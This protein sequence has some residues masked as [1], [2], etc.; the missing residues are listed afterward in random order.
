M[1]GGALTWTNATWP[2]AFF[3]P[4]GVRYVSVAGRAVRGNRDADRRTV[5]GYAAG[6]YQ[7][8]RVRPWCTGVRA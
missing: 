4:A 3:A 7:Q 6:S 1:T 8:V 5:P 2:G